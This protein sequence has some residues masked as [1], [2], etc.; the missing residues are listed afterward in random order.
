MEPRATRN[1]DDKRD[2]AF[3]LPKKSPDTSTETRPNKVSFETALRLGQVLDNQFGKIDIEMT[4][5]KPDRRFYSAAI[6]PRQNKKSLRPTVFCK[7]GG[8][9]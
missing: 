9:L 8:F 2:S 5:S 4:V 7:D 6:S 3:N 1:Q